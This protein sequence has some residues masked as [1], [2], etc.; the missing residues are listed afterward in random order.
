MR[1]LPTSRSTQAECY[2][3]APQ[4]NVMQASHKHVIEQNLS[5]S[6]VT[7]T[8]TVPDDRSAS[9]AIPGEAEQV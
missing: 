2:A 7:N 4:G 3:T 8:L 9:S 6:N 5:S 1:P